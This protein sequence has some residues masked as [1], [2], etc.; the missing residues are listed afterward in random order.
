MLHSWEYAAF[1]MDCCFHE[2][3]FAGDK[4]VQGIL[5]HGKGILQHGKMLEECMPVIS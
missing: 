5:Q 4:G 1:E 3:V 2:V